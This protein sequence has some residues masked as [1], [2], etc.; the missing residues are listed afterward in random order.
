M[1]LLHLDQLYDEDQRLIRADVATCTTGTVGKLGRDEEAELGALFHE[2]HAF[3]PAS[4]DAVQGELD[5]LFPLIRAVKQ[6]SKT[7]NK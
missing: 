3:C 1:R 6:L 7:L 2:L 4:D 5:G